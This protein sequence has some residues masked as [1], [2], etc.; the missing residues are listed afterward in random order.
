MRR[1]ESAAGLIFLTFDDGPDPSTTPLILDI[2]KRTNSKATFF[3][4]AKKAKQ[5]P[6]LVRKILADG[7]AIGNHSLDHRYTAFFAGRDRMLAWV[8]ESIRM[9]ADAGAKHPIGF[10][11]PA[12]I[13][14]PKLVAALKLRGLPLVLWERRFYDTVFPWTPSDARRAARSIREGAIVL[15]HDGRGVS[16]L[17]HSGTA[18]EEFVATVKNRGLNFQTLTREHGDTQMEA[19]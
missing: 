12:G 5:H 17:E 14:N 7:H 11:P 9:L 6:A 18:L 13:V 19:K 4:V 2:L 3:L 16:W 15:L 10:R 1:I 8:D